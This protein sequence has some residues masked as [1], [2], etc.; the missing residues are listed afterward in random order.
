M[1]MTLQ[2]E[3]ITELD[4]F[5]QKCEQIYPAN[6]LLK[7]DLHC[8]DY[9][10]DV[11]DELLGRILNLP[12]TWLKT[13]RLIE[14]L[15][16]N[17]CS[18]FTI[19]NHNNARSCY[20]M[21]DKGHD[22]LVGTEFSCTVPDYNVGI[23][24]LTYGFTAEQEGRLN[25][26]RKN[27]YAFLDY[28]NSNQIPTIWAHPLYHYSV[29]GAI[30]MSFFGKMALVFDRFEVINGQRDTWQ[31]MLVKTWIERLDRDEI[32]RLAKEIGIN[33]YNYSV[34]PYKKSLSGGSDDHMGIF[35]GLSGT[36][37]Y[38]PGL[39]EKLKTN[40]PSELALQA[41]QQGNM[42]P[43][44]SHQNA[45][46]LTIAF[47]DYVCQIALNH[48]D[49][50][51]MR[52]LLHKGTTNDK[53]LALAVSNAFGELRRHNITMRFIDVFHNCFMGKKPNMAKS[54]FIPKV[55]KP[56]FSEAGKIAAIRKHQTEDAASEIS[57]SIDK[58]NTQLS[59]TL[60]D[61]I[62]K[63]LKQLDALSISGTDINQFI[64]QLEIPSEFRVL[65]D[66]DAKTVH[67]TKNKKKKK[68][69]RMTTPDLP[70]LLDG[71]PFPF[72][73]SSVLLAAN[74]TST[75]VLFKSRN[76]L[77]NFAGQLNKFQY[78]KRM[79]W[80]TDTFDD[81]NGVSMVLQAMHKEIK[82]RNLPIDLLVCS[83]TLQPDDHLI[84]VKPISEFTLDFYPEQP[85]RI[86][87]FLEI[88]HL[89]YKNEYDRLICSTEGIMGLMGLYLKN[90]Y[91]V[92]AFFY[93]H[94]DWLMFAR[95][96]LNIDRNNLNRVRRLMRAFYKGF[97]GLF[98]LNTDQ[99]N[100][101]M[102]REMGFKED[103]IFLTAHWADEH[104]KPV[105][106]TKSQ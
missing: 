101:L 98:V 53:I 26:L 76:L 90:A 58:M 104:F 75:K 10:S 74:F 60:F 96:V 97:D 70:K 34:N 30:P 77:N 67:T 92:P 49:P 80:L 86:P 17:D 11:P 1:Y 68:N 81:K 19:T 84:V 31:N 4:Q 38:V 28:A 93:L 73:A 45:E 88:H 16:K 44:G 52:I 42:Y 7:I 23:H 9:N 66:P 103:E 36:H 46:K 63:K 13:N 78:P 95:K 27:L 65:V 5:L 59:K 12:E 29:N 14:T 48:K 25:K 33:P 3:L 54:F 51:L 47:L 72:L 62:E 69:S 79:L 99:Q 57:Q 37:L 18:A 24:V 8:H 21:L 106:A 32:D 89:F 82:Q 55:Y 61:R 102:E 87:D 15:K 2:Q 43:Y 50:G 6:D 20:E 100:W 35:A 40:K 56:V 105:N 94:T 39:N 41:I 91:H 22:I 71:L 85:I 83:S 64:N